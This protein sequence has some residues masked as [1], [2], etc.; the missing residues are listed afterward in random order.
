MTS[1]ICYSSVQKSDSSAVANY[2]PISL[3]CTLCKL[4]ESVIKD[5][6]LSRFVS[7]CLINKHQH[8]FISKHST[9]TNFWS[10][11]L[12]GKLPVDVIYI[13]FSKA[14]DSVAH[15]KLIHKPQ[16][17]GRPIKGLLLKWIRAFLHGRSQCI[18]VENRYSSGQ[19]WRS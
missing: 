17:F 1:S 19:R 5:Q 14:F 7:K 11:A 13:D 8:G 2:R 4:T 6:L 9:I 15:S 12:H 18:V 3:T 16:T 10:L